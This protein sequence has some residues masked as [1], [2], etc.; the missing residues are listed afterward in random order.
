M[1]IRMASSRAHAYTSTTWPTRHGSRARS[2]SS[3]IVS[4]AAA[5]C[6]RWK[7]GSMIRRARRW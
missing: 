1:A 2:A 3:H 5:T 6:S 7:A 4:A